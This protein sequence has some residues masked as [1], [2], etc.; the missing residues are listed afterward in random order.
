MLEE[1]EYCSGEAID[2]KEWP[3]LCAGVDRDEFEDEKWGLAILKGLDEEDTVAGAGPDEA[4]RVDK[5]G[6]V[7]LTVAYVQ[8]RERAE[9]RARERKME[10]R[11]ESPKRTRISIYAAR[12]YTRSL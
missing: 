5:I 9:H 8:V 1:E 2:P 11:D 7:A 10:R 3:V 6:N 12:N 4:V